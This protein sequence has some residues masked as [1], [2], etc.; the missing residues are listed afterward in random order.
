[1][2]KIVDLLKGKFMPLVLALMMTFGSYAPT[3]IAITSAPNRSENSVRIV[4]QNLRCN[5]DLYGFVKNRAQFVTAM[6]KN[7]APDS[8]GVQEA[9]ET[10]LSYIDEALSENYARVGQPRDDSKNTEYSAVYY[11][12]DK[13]DL[14]DEGTIWLSETPEEFGSKSFLATMPRVCTWATLKNKTTGAVYTHINTHLDFL[15]EYTRSKQADVLLSKVEELQK[16]GAV[17]C[18]GDFNADEKAET[19]L[20]MTAALEDCRLVAKESESGKTY[21]N[22]GRADLLHS[23]AIDFIF[24]TKGTQVERYKIIKDTVDGMYLSDHYGIM[25]DIIFN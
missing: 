23:T 24:V 4:S 8:F 22:Y 17:V 18:T 6:L 20:K 25:A 21:H 2:K 9:T 10:W 14:L 19:Y 13:F 3:E 5:N 7:Y 15:V 1:M 12:T 16:R 11:R